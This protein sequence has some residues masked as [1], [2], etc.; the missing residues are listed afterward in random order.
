[1]D[2]VG[3]TSNS[4]STDTI[5][6]GKYRKSFLFQFFSGFE[7]AYI[8]FYETSNQ[9]IDGETLKMKLFRIYMLFSVIHLKICYVY[10]NYYEISMWIYIF[11]LWILDHV[12]N[13]GI[14]LKVLAVSFYVL[15][16]HFCTYWWLLF[17]EIPVLSLI[18]ECGTATCCKTRTCI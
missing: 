10:S 14:L 18:T 3:N 17:L 8:C 1:M 2:C 5:G 13:I 11:S 7:T 16:R 6:S 4:R 9:L 12:S 15:I